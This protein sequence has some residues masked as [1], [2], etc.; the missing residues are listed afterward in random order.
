MIGLSYRLDLELQRVADAADKAADKA[1]R[2]VAYA[3]AQEAKRSIRRT[4]SRK[5]APEGQPPRTRTGRAKKAVRYAMEIRGYQYVVGFAASVIGQ[6]MGAHERG[7]TYKG[8]AFPQRPT[9]GPALAHVGPLL[10]R[11]WEGRIGD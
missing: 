7:E 9:M 1:M 4:R 2:P 3:A 6:A 8:T 5:P 11:T 10:G